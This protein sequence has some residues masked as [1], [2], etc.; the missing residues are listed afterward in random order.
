MRPASELLRMMKYDNMT[1]RLFDAIGVHQTEFDLRN[2][3]HNIGDQHERSDKREL[4]L[5]YSM[6]AILGQDIF[7]TCQVSIV[8]SI[9]RLSKPCT[10]YNPFRY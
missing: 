5:D 10:L 7:E 2:K 3:T 8:I 4:R 9:T 6:P 1:L